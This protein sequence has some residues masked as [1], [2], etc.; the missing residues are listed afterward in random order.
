[1]ASVATFAVVQPNAVKGL[2]GSSI[3]GTKLHVK[4]SSLGLK[5][6]KTRAGPVVAKYGDKSVYFDLEDL[7]NT[8]GQ[9][10]LYGSDAPSPYNSLQSKFFE[11][12]AAPFT[13][14]GLLLKFLLLGSGSLLAYVS[15]TASPDYL[16]IKKGPQLPPKPGPR[17]KI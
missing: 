2:A 17:G 8:T 11:T 7:G 10:D 15:A 6:S 3:S 16:P 13:K 4:P 12:F 1:M 9:W 14:R 5:P